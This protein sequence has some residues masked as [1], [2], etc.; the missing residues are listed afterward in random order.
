MK[1]RKKKRQLT[2]ISQNA[3]IC[4]HLRLVVSVHQPIT[5]NTGAERLQVSCPVLSRSLSHSGR[6][7]SP[8]LVAG[9]SEVI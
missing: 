1:E 7:L 8:L 6:P 5:S 4:T 9:C 3:K 2:N